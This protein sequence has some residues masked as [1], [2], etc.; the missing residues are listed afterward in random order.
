MV[1]VLVTSPFT[2]VGFKEIVVG[3]SEASDTSNPKLAQAN[4]FKSQCQGFTVV[5][6][7]PR[8]AFTV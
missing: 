7:W 2:R 6:S 4:Y 1:A 3:F 5:L 8:I